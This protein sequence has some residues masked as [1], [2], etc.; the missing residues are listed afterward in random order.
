MK[1]EI[2]IRKRTHFI[3]RI[4]ENDHVLFIRTKDN[5]A[6]LGTKFSAFSDVTDRLNQDSLF[7]NG[8]R[9]SMIK[10]PTELALFNNHLLMAATGS[11]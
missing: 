9:R 10:S 1:T 11:S 8:A 7:R 5:P 4:F 3:G 2:Y 6:D